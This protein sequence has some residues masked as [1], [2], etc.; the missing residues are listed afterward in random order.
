MDFSFS[1]EQDQLRAQARSFLEKRFPAARLAEIA[2]SKDGWDRASWPEL[3]R[4]GWTGASIPEAQGGAGLSFVEEAI[5][6]EELGRALYAGPY[7]TTVALALPSLAC[8]PDLLARV[9]SGALTATLAS[10]TAMEARRAGDRWLLRGET[11]LVPDAG[12]VE[13]FVVHARGPDGDGLYLAERHDARP[14]IRVLDTVDVTRR[15]GHVIFDDDEGRLLAAP[16]DAAEIIARTRRRALAALALEAVGIGSQA[17]ALGVSHAKTREQ[18]GRPIGAYQAVSHKLADT[19]VEMELARSLAYW[20]AWCIAEDD[21]Q[22]DLA[23]IA[24]KA[25]AAE[26]AVAACERAIQ[27]HGG[28]GF[29]WDHP[30]HRYYKRALW[31]ESFDR[32]GA[33]HRAEIAQVLLGG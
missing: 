13:A 28:M 8:A 20:A 25:Y 19:Y 18:F 30:L 3:A 24:A 31:I 26:A 15:L 29:T 10:G 2:T 17:L 33:A 12:W 1:P 22:A 23:A 4:L 14:R 27:V 16:P 11:D 6:F 21:G 5:V 7:F 9:A 32:S